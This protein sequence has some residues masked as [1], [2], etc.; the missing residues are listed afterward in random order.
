MAQYWR[1]RDYQQPSRLCGG[2]IES[3]SAPLDPRIQH[4]SVRGFVPARVCLTA[5]E[6][7]QIISEAIT[8][9]AR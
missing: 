9:I 2:Q 7:S 6:E 8:T 4:L 3:G 1:V 5:H